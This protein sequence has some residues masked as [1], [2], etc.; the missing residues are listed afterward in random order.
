M[1][2]ID[3]NTICAAQLRAKIRLAIEAHVEDESE[4]C[5]LFGY[6]TKNR[7]SRSR[8]IVSDDASIWIVDIKDISREL[9]ITFFHT[10]SD[11]M[12]DCKVPYLLYYDQV[13]YIRLFE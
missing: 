10:I 12:A 1:K 9:C 7:A 5:N 4:L 3:K 13:E 6:V 2:T 8:L 11:V